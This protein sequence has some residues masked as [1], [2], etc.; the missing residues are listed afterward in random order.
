MQVLQVIAA[1]ARTKS[2]AS[3]ALPKPH[4]RVKSGLP[5]AP[6]AQPAAPLHGPKPRHSGTC[7]NEELQLRASARG[8]VGCSGL[9]DSAM[10][11][12]AV[13]VPSRVACGGHALNCR[14]FCEF[15]TCDGCRCARG[16]REN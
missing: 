14:R 10:L 11:K 2:R 8:A 3:W 12:Q 1:K 4:S 5:N 13:G 15:H 6:A 7:A 9:L 16:S